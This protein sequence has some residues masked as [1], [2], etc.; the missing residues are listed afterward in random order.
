MFIEPRPVQTLF[1]AKPLFDPKALS[2][3]LL[4]RQPQE[5]V[6]I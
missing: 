2:V 1:V 4:L 6:T 3:T 5:W